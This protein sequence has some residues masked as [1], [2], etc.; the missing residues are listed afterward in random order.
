MDWKFRIA[1]TTKIRIWLKIYNLL[2]SITVFFQSF[3]ANRKNGKT[4]RYWSS[5]LFVVPP[6]EYSI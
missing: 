2:M 4:S 3:L 6:W 1:M 5:G